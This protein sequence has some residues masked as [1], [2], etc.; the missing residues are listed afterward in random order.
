[1]GKLVICFPISVSS[2]KFVSAPRAQRSNK[3]VVIVLFKSNTVFASSLGK[4]MECFTW[5]C[6]ASTTSSLA[7]VSLTDRCDLECI[8][9]HARIV[10]LEF[11]EA[12]INNVHNAVDRQR[13]F[14]DVRRHLRIDSSQVTSISS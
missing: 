7:S 10:D 13:R 14:S 11:R 8:H 2:P 12:S 5:P 9:S 3:L 6:P 4:K 1:M